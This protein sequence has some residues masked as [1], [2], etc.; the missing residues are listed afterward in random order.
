ML[1]VKPVGKT[2]LEKAF[3]EQ[4]EL[5][6]PAKVKNYPLIDLNNKGEFTFTLKKEH[7]DDYDENGEGL[8]IRSWFNLY[9]EEAKVSTAGI[10]GLQNPLY[11]WDT[12]YPLNLIGMMLATMGKI[13]VAKDTKTP[14]EKIV[15]CEVRY[16]ST[17][18]VELIA[19]LQAAYGLTTHVTANYT[20]IPIFM[21]SFII[22]MNDFYGGEYVTSSHAMAKKIATKDLNAQGS[23][24]IPSESLQFVAKVEQILKEVEEK[25]EYTFKI[26]ARDNPNI[27]EEF[28]KAAAN[29]VTDYVEYLKHG[30]ATP[31]NLSNIKALT[32]KIVIDTVGGSLINT[33]DPVLTKLGIREH[34]D[35]VHAAEDPFNHA[36]GKTMSE[37]GKF[38][39]WSCDTTIMKADL[40][41]MNIK[42]PV[43]NTIN[44][45][46]ILKDYP[47]GTVLLMT[48]PDADRLVTSYVD[49]IKNADKIKNMGLVFT[50]LNDNRI[51]VV[52]TPNQSFL[53]NMDFQ[54][55]ALTEAGLWD[56]Y[57]WFLLKTTASQR[58]WDE[59]A[60][61]VG[62]PVVNTPVGFKELADSM[63]NIEKKMAAQ[64]DQPV[65]I[66]DVF[67]ESH[68]LGKNPRMLFAG[69][70]SGGEIYG[71]AELIQSKAGRFAIS[72][73]EK[74]A[75]E[76]III[77][78][79]MVKWLETKQ[80]SLTDYLSSIFETN[81][82]D[83]KY[84]IRVDQKYYNESEP[85]ISI[86]LKEKEK[87]MQTK[88]RN[89]SFFLTLA[90]GYRDKLITLDQVKA[91]LSEC[92]KELDFSDLQDIKFCGDGTYILFSKKCLEVRPS[93]TDA[94]NKAYAFGL[95]QW[96]CIKFAQAFSVYN[97]DRTPLHEQLIPQA[98]Y[99]RIEQ[100]AFETYTNYKEHQ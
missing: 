92:F 91:I 39:D 94:V 53:M 34:F 79:A 8:G 45:T 67:G 74:S 37:E 55:K 12:R 84:E 62:I 93:G 44:Y 86:L 41:T 96:E 56:K 73:R 1:F 29:G 50:P 100:L 95:D 64:P 21:I 49:D 9:K 82:I 14:K 61:S 70:E 27:N 54:Q 97:G 33:F 7:L 26:A 66:K 69:E 2:D 99:D 16:N 22:F 68:N 40:K 30:I 35:F 46:G 81:K 83:F 20:T 75:G 4:V 38:F 5:D 28:L 88:T 65:T 85:D 43:I 31:T 59:W 32:N 87:G 51:L 23:Q 13:L 98:Y 57:D 60:K 24:Y 78:A 63:I 48:D 36:V 71:P 72:M 10:R 76:A 52:F 11:P 80:L 6:T 89:N 77:T 15:A 25:G 47:I 17:Q 90:F 19:R 18:Y 3:L 42:V 58:S